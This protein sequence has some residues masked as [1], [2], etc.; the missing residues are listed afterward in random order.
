MLRCV[1][2]FHNIVKKRT[3]QIERHEIK[4]I[5]SLSLN[6]KSLFQSQK[7]EDE[8]EKRRTSRQMICFYHF[9]ILRRT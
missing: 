4:Q 1:V 5:L 3:K 2:F 8:E 7:K 9:G 6:S